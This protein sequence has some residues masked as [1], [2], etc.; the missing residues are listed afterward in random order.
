M[1]VM[2]RVIDKRHLHDYVTHETLHKKAYEFMLER[3]QHYMRE[4]HRRHRALIVMDDTNKSL[5]R[6]VAMKHAWFQRAG[7]RDMTFPAIVEYPFFTRSELSNG[8]QLADLLAYNIYRAFKTEDFGYP[9]F[10]AMLPSIYR[11]RDGWA[12]DG[13]KIW[14]DDSPLVGAAQRAWDEYKRVSHPLLPK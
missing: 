9:F 2:A 3:I 12:L 7:N 4:Y 11:R 8:I 5:N 1:V 6:A 13:L 10:R 14:P